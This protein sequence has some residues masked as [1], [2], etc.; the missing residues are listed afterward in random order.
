MVCKILEC[1]PDGTSK[2]GEWFGGG[3]LTVYKA[4][5]V[6]VGGFTFCSLCSFSCIA[7]QVTTLKQLRL[8]SCVD[9]LE[10][11]IE[12]LGVFDNK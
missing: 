8:L 9:S 5:V 7:N 6:G 12:P 3:R 11:N 10:T 4:R 1:Y 2:H